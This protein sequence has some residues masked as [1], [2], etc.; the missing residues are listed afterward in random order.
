MSI[1]ALAADDPRNGLIP[2]DSI[3]TIAFK[4]T[5]VVRRG[6]FTQNLAGHL[7]IGTDTAEFEIHLLSY[8]DADGAARDRLR[9]T[10][11]E[12]LEYDAGDQG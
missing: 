5:Q 7:E 2:Y 8:P 1:E 6:S 4:P 3:K 9:A 10:F 11:G 12:R